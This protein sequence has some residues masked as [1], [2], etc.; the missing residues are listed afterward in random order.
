[1]KKFIGI[2]FL[3]L[4]FQGIKAQDDVTLNYQGVDHKKIHFG[5]T[6]GF[7]TMDFDIT[8]SMQPYGADSAVLIPELNDLVPGFHVGIVSDLRLN[9]NW[10]LRFLPGISLGQRKILFYDSNQQVV[11]EMKIESTFIDL[12]LSLKYKSVRIHNTRP[13]LI[14]GINIRNDMARNKEFNED[15]EI[16]IKLKPFDLYYEI[17]VGIDFY[18][19]YFKFSTEIKYSVG[20]LNVVSSDVYEDHP[21]YANS[22]DKMKSRMF[23]VSLHFE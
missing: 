11:S 20:S 16:Y 15:E 18:L 5:F 8:P 23:M 21:Q 3:S 22:I 13:Y 1:M 12:P 14:G 17:G 10:N 6:V 19:A 7:N 9:D 2:L 4:F